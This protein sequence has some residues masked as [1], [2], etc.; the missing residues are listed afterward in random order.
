[1]AEKWYN[2]TVGEGIAIMAIA[3]G[4]GALGIVGGTYLDYKGKAESSKILMEDK[5][6]KI[7]EANL[8]GSEIPE[9]FYVIDGKVAIIEVDG[10]PALSGLEKI[11]V[12]KS[13][14][15]KQ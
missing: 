2:S 11:A 4:V 6:Y 14:D 1:M 8:I 15:I 12:E 3:L 9:K 7:Q 5:E 10:K 13:E